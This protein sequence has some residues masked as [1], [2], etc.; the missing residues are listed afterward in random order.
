M[1]EHDEDYHPGLL[2]P[3]WRVPA[4]VVRTNISVAESVADRSVRGLRS[5]VSPLVP[6][7]SQ[8]PATPEE[9]EAEAR[10]REERLASEDDGIKSP[11]FV[12]LGSYKPQFLRDLGL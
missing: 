8:L 5:A 12:M 9:R 10:A 4:A 6:G 11:G 7:R 2:S 3:L 1:A